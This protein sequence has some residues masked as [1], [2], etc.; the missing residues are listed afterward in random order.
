MDYLNVSKQTAYN[1]IHSLE[2]LDLIKKGQSSYYTYYYLSSD[3]I[4][5]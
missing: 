4:H 5:I 1:R 3:R 2:D